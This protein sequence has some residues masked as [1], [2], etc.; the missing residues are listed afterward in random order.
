MSLSQWI[1][2]VALTGVIA[3]AVLLVVAPQQTVLFCAAVCLGIA[4]AVVIKD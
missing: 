3:C 1:L 4:I 2:N